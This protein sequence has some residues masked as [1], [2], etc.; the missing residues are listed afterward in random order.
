MKSE[1]ENIYSAFVYELSKIT[2]EN[3]YEHDIGPNIY[4]KN[5]DPSD[6]PAMVVTLDS[7]NTAERNEDDTVFTRE[8]ILKLTVHFIT[9]SDIS[10]E[11]LIT[12]EQMKWL[13]DIKRFVNGHNS[14]KHFFNIYL[15]SSITHIWIDKCVP[16]IDYKNNKGKVT[17]LINIHYTEEFI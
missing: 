6:Y 1:I 16:D 12:S 14:V 17:V 2:K 4:K 3:G 7:E 10:A 5:I 8:V 15:L 13:W 9:A 11:G